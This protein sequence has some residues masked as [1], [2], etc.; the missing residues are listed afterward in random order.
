[1]RSG[2]SNQRRLA[3]GLGK[4][5]AWFAISRVAQLAS[6]VWV[7]RQLDP[8]DFTL[9]A[10]IFACQGLIQQISALNLTSELVRARSIKNEDLSVAW[11]YEFIRNLLIWI[12]LVAFAPLLAAGMKHP[13]LAGGIQLSA[14][15][16]LIGSF[17]NPRLI[18][19]R[20]EGKFGR[21]GWIESAPL[22]VYALS[23]VTF[24]WMRPDFYSLIYAGLAS[25]L[26]GV[27]ISYH[28]LP[29]K[30]TLN[31]DF[32]RLR[33]MLAFGLVLLIGSFFLA[34]RQHGIVFIVSANGLGGDLGYL[35]RGLAFSMVLALQGVG[36]FWKVAY[37]HYATI[38]LQ[39]GNVIHD[40]IEVNRWLLLLAL[41]VALLLGFFS[42]SI[43][44]FVLGEKWQPVAPLWAWL[45]V[46]GTLMLC[47]APLEA[48]LQ[49]LRLEKTQ[50][51]ISAISTCIYFTLAWFLLSTHGIVAVG[52]GAC[53]GNILSTIVLR[54]FLLKQ[55]ANFSV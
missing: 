18:E 32:Q 31:F 13:E 36:L 48:A 2:S 19:L 14:C 35:N 54:F 22:M 8:R 9:L 26:S 1:M 11:S 24:V 4:T 16:L 21:L 23:A 42:E 7:T 27:L 15:G 3:F 12:I 25:S 52:I 45:V 5:G 43:I 40:A 44:S 6:G 50:L 37:P 49:A 29:W 53:A 39:G 20:R 33:P 38:H 17:R 41:P 47:N 30:L 10:V 34:L 55:K 28:R 51:T 46:S